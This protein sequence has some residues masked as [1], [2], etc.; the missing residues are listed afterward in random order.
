V[1]LIFLRSLGL[2]DRQ[3]QTEINIVVASPDRNPCANLCENADEFLHRMC[4]VLTLPT[5][6]FETRD[7]IIPGMTQLKIRVLAILAGLLSCYVL[8]GR[9]HA[10]AQVATNTTEVMLASASGRDIAPKRHPCV[11]KLK[12]KTATGHLRWDATAMKRYYDESKKWEGWIQHEALVLMAFL[13]QQQRRAGITGA[14]GEIGVHHGRF[15]AAIFG[16]SRVDE[17][18][19]A[20]DLF[21]DQS[22]NIDKSGYGSLEAFERNLES[23][24]VG[25]KAGA[26]I[27]VINSLK[28][29]ADD[30]HVLKVDGMRM[31]SVDGGH[32]HLTTLNDLLLACDLIV[33]GGIVI[34]DDFVHQM[35]LGVATGAIEFLRGQERIVAFA[36]GFNKLFLTTA[37]HHDR[38]LDAIRALDSKLCNNLL[39]EEINGRYIFPSKMCVL[40]GIERDNNLKAALLGEKVLLAS[41]QL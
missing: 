12:A 39:S 21:G 41:M 25:R 2:F 35:W 11:V 5:S 4:L 36:W 9:M 1:L 26:I 20:A 7:A 16:T 19:W 18:M 34:V 24:G 27:S 28:L 37:S 32:T 15:T 40:V 38:Y 17:P 22:E 23:V 14:V 33:D 30:L 31:L 6:L 10:S 3:R 13:S 29:K 8:V